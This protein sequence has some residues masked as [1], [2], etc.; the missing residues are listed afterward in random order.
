MIVERSTA[1]FLASNGPSNDE[2]IHLLP[3]SR[4]RVL[5]WQGRCVYALL[6]SS[7]NLIG[8]TS[9]DDGNPVLTVSILTDLPES[10]VAVGL[11]DAICR[12]FIE[13]DSGRIRIVGFV[14][15]RERFKPRR[16]IPKHVRDQVIAEH[17]MVCWLCKGT[18]RTT[19]TL[20]LDHVLAKAKGGSDHPSNLRPAHASCNGRKGSAPVTVFDSRIARLRARAIARGE[21][22]P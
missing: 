11:P 22:S 7:V 9:V 15:E 21:V 6:K 1:D 18:I 14:A 2:F 13:I 8:E 20:H 5:S 10:I 12:Q 17:G 19:K 16:P 4:W 3:N